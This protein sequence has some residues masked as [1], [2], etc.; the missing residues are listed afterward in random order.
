MPLYDKCVSH[1]TPFLCR[2]ALPIDPM[3]FSSHSSSFVCRECGEGVDVEGTTEVGGGASRI[4]VGSVGGVGG[5]EDSYILLQSTIAEAGSVALGG[6]GG[7]P[8]PAPPPP[9]GG[10][11]GRAGRAG[12]SRTGGEP[13][14][15]GLSRIG[16]EP[17][18]G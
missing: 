8:C 11:A 14:P 2:Y 6:L 9:L 10:V 18:R 5:L 15:S 4:Q 12:V 1:S 16:V 17:H 3:S 13:H 7:V